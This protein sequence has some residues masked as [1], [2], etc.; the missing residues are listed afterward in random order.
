MKIFSRIKCVTTLPYETRK[1]IMLSISTGSITKCWRVLFCRPLSL[2]TRRHVCIYLAHFIFSSVGLKRTNSYPL[3][4][5][6]SSLLRMNT[7]ANIAWLWSRTFC[8]ILYLTANV[9]CNINYAVLNIK[10]S[11]PSFRYEF[12]WKS[13]PSCY[14]S[15]IICVYPPGNN[16]LVFM[17]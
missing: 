8:S 13:S 9:H 14:S 3:P 6:C 10:I 5:V 16:L 12:N 7:S 4:T 1:Q 11:P 17:F 15:I 2:S